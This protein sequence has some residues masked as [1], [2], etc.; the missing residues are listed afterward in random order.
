MF[1]NNPQ[2]PRI[3]AA[4]VCLLVSA[5]SGIILA[6]TPVPGGDVS[7]TW[8]LAGSPYLVNGEISV[9]LDQTLTVEPGVEVRFQGWYKFI[10]RGQLLAVGTAN[11]TIRF[12]AEVP[13]TGWH[14]LRFL[15]TETNAQPRSEVRFCRIQ[16]G[17]AWGSCPDNSGGGIY[18][19][20]SS[21]TIA[22]CLIR[23][24]EAL[25]GMAAWGG[26]G[27]YCDFASNVSILDN[28]IAGNRTDHDGGG[29]YCQWSSPDIHGNTV[30]GNTAGRGAGLACFNNASPDVRGNDISAN[31]GEGVYLSGGFAWLVNNTVTGNQGSGI[32][33]YLT[34]PY[35]IGN[36][37]TGNT[38]LR[39]GGIRNEGSSPQ[40]TNNTIADNT[41]TIQGGG[42]YNTF[43]MVGVIQPSNP[44]C[45]NDI[46][47][48]NTAP[49][50]PQIYTNVNCTAAVRYCDIEDFSG[51]GCYGGISTGPGMIEDPPLFDTAGFHPYALTSSSPCLDVGMPDTP[52]L[53][54]LDLAGNDRIVNDIVDMGAYEFDEGIAVPDGMPLANMALSQN[55]PN[56]FNPITV[57]SFT[58]DRTQDVTLT[59]FDPLGRR[60]ATVFEGRAEAGSNTVTWTGVDA[61][62]RAVPSGMYVYRLELDTGGSASRRMTLVR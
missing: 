61:L 27:I 33:C 29:I 23:D 1:L 14:S 26:G 11:D 15:D 42:I 58:L 51:A 53:P 22:D 43:V 25:Y 34:N 46:L 52:N 31:N 13:A 44:S 28:V 8:A 60:V 2:T 5:M 4:F 37:I 40:V 56:P 18:I 21:V 19:A 48:G 41:A 24:N 39:G 3:V 20:Y 38:A 36:L 54:T 55:R 59:V 32:H 16:D 47:W 50:G 62:G 12:L 57:I 35:I 7:G 49:T 9:P 6:D 10:I 30:T 45:T 17:Y